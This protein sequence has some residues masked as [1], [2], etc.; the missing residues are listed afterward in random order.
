MQTRLFGAAEAVVPAYVG[1]EQCVPGHSFGPAVRECYLLHYVICG[2]GTYSVGGERYTLRAGQA[3]LIRPGEVTLYRADSD[4][5]WGYLWLAFYSHHPAFLSLPYVI[6]NR[7]LSGL[8]NRHDYLEKL[9]RMNPFHA[10]ALTWSV[11]AC[12]AETKYQ[13]EPVA[14]YTERAI[15][16]IEQRYT[17][18]LTVGEMAAALHIDRSYFS[19]L[20]KSR[21]GKSPQQYLISYRLQRAEELLKER[22]Y[23]VSVVAASVGFTDVFA[24]SRC[25]K[26]HYGMSP[27]AFR[28]GV[29]PPKKP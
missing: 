19:G 20:F 15:A 7:E 16:L 21:T 1:G 24:F 27:S 29:M 11:A 28:A 10:A 13:T 14:N 4:D 22:R 17:E 12:L 2:T 9:P 8:L 23:S 26:Q 18:R 25:F 3:F 5:P 6:E